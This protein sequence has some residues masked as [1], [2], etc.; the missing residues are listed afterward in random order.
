MTW[1]LF[2]ALVPAA[3][4]LCLFRS[5][6]ARSLIWWIGVLVFIVFLPN[7][8]Y[9]LTDIIHLVQEIQRNDSLLYN[10]L[11]VIPKYI[12]FVLVGFG[13]YVLALMYLGHYLKRQNLESMVLQVEL[14]LHG[15]CAI[16]VHLGRFERFN[17]WDLMTRPH[18]IIH[19]IAE[20]LL[21]FRPL[22][23]MGASFGAIAGLY[24]L[25]KEISLALVFKHQYQKNLEKSPNQNW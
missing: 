1:N 22:I 6:P 5:T 9:V 17:S 11:V 25:L 14:T 24:W 10:T 2:L 21:D 8:P 15:L 4:G 19:T 13:G 20:N 16:G 7:A 3:L 18:H 23:F 12:I